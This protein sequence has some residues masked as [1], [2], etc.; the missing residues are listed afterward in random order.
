MTWHPVALCF[1]CL[2]A[3]VICGLHPNCHEQSAAVKDISLAI[4]G[5]AAGN[6]MGASKR[7][8]KKK[9]PQPEP[10]RGGDAG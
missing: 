10:A 1:M 6:A 7:H 5:F 9:D 3:I 4:V 8:V 2:L